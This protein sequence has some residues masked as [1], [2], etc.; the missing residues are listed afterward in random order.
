MRNAVEHLG[1]LDEQGRDLGDG[2]F[3]SRPRHV[4]QDDLDQQSL[5]VI[6]ALTFFCLLV[7]L[8]LGFKWMTLP[9]LS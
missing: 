8:F 6:V 1:E 5:P 9:P 4:P 7:A 3:H 2:V